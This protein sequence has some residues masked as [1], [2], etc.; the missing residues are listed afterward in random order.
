VS[1]FCGAHR[2]PRAGIDPVAD[3]STALA[4]IQLAMHRP[5]IAETIALVLEVDR[6]GRTVVVV[7]GTDDPDSVLDVVER[8]AD[9]IA[10]TGRD[11]A[12]VLASVRPHAGPLP[13]DGDRWL[14]ASE[15]ADAAGVELI[16][17]FVIDDA[18]GQHAAWCPR[19]LLGEPP[20]WSRW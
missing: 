7:D 17:W 2:A 1:K 9:S 13:G 12:L 20:R 4:V 10:S 11:G 3:A 14:E 6:R 16:E 18:A 15:L 8:L 19:D 5:L